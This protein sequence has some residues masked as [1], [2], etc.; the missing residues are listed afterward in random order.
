M[1]TPDIFA[2]KPQVQK[3]FEFPDPPER[4]PD[5]MTSFDH[6]AAN[7]NVYL[8]IEYLGNPETT[9]VAGEH[10]IS[11]VPTGEMAGL[12]YPDLFVAFEVDPVAY[13]RSNAYII[14]EQGKPPDFVLEIASRRT[15]RIDVTEKREDYAALGIEE[16]WRFDETGDYHGV[17]LAGERLVE[18][19]YVAMDIEELPDGSLQ[20]YSVALNLNIRWERGELRFCDPGTGRPIATLADEREA[21]IAEQEA[22]AAAEARADSAEARVREL[23]EQVPCQGP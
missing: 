18:G 22:R 10:Y 8:L 16:Y 21:R 2:R 19:E 17:R 9:L 11:P 7:G 12:R 14:S 1:T 6:L 4:E 15:G 5:D 13:H 23:E 20:G 3:P